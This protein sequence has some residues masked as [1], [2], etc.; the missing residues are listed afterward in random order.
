[1]SPNPNPAYVDKILQ[2]L[3][4]PSFPPNRSQWRKLELAMEFIKKSRERAGGGTAEQV[5]PAASV[6]CKQSQTG[7]RKREEHGMENMRK[8]ATDDTED[9]K[10]TV[11]ISD[12]KQKSWS[13]I[14]HSVT[15][16]L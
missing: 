14:K 3:L 5:A 10:G 11:N 15:H 9:Q 16:I 7:K 4:V 1:M 6:P 2:T 12:K 13:K 8:N